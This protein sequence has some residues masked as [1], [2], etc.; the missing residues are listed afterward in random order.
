MR[1]SSLSSAVLLAA[2]T[3]GCTYKATPDPQLS[4]RD[5]EW[6]AKVPKAEEDRI[7]ARYLV[8]DPTGEAPGTVVV[9]TKQRL[10]F[11]VRPDRKAMRY[12]VGVGDGA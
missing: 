9:D 12:G 5:A 6:M 7:F 1:A 4:A 10:L 8:E 11:S 2:L 3:S